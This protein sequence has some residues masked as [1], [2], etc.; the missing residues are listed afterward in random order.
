MTPHN[1]PNTAFELPFDDEIALLHN[2]YD[3]KSF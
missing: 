1:D 2:D 3:S